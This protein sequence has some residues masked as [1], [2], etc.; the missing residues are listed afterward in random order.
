M[1]QPRE[2]SWA[3][4]AARDLDESA[5]TPILR[6]LL[7]RGRGVLMVCFVDFEGECVDYCSTLP[8]YDAKVAGAQMLVTL[9]EVA[10]RMHKLGGGETYSMTIHA[11]P[12]ELVVRRVSA[13][14]MLVVTLRRGSLTRRL[15]GGIEHAVIELRREAA[16]DVPS[17]D[18][19]MDSVRVDVRAAIGWSYAPEAFFADDGSRQEIEIVLGRWFDRGRS[20]VCFRV[21]TVQ[22]EELTLIHDRAVDRWERG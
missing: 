19:V 6:R 17:W 22:G 2:R 12:R 10:A 13:E 3:K 11:A 1:T 7:Y 4:E 5:F 16:I 9:S 15:R 20:R 18:P 21:R 8:P 14:Y